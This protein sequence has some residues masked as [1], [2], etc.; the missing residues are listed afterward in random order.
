MQ[1]R[2]LVAHPDQPLPPYLEL[3]W[4]PDN[5]LEALIEAEAEYRLRSQIGDGED[6]QR[7]M[8]HRDR[9]HKS[10]S[11]TL[12]NVVMNDY[13]RGL[14]DLFLLFHTGEITRA[15]A[16]VPADRFGGAERLAALSGYLG[17][18]LEAV[19]RRLPYGEVNGDSGAEETG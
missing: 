12:E 1:P 10:M 2:D 15:L 8:T 3:G 19:A 14:V 4:Q 5:D 18:Y 11:A 7:M 9:Y 17:K 6:K 16:K 13:H